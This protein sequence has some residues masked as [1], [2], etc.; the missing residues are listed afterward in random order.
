[1][2]R[3]KAPDSTEEIAKLH[4]VHAEPSSGNSFDIGSVRWR[5]DGGD[6]D[7]KKAMSYRL[8]FCWN[9]AEG[10]PLEA[11]EAGA[12][13]RYYEA[14][15]CLALAIEEDPDSVNKALDEFR[16]AEKALKVDISHGRLH[17]CESCLAK[18]K[19]DDEDVQDR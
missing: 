18:E 3:K 11:L 12:V 13:D 2:T 15:R 16:S 14:A 19:V 5:G 7:L 6:N 9:M 4:R 17:D 1:M 8:S 10:I